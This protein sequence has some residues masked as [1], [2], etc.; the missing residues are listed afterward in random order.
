MLICVKKQD[1]DFF[2]VKLSRKKKKSS[3]PLIFSTHY[4]GVPLFNYNG[5]DFS[6]MYGLNLCTKQIVTGTYIFM[7]F[8]VA[9]D[10]FSLIL[11]H[12]NNAV[13]NDFLIFSVGTVSERRFC[14]IPFQLLPN[15][16]HLPELTTS[17]YVVESCRYPRD[18]NPRLA[19]TL[20]SGPVF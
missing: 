13:M 11:S 10:Y 16:I 5:P 9:R 8:H 6:K 15:E 7:E 3:H 14:D 19:C 1:I 18:C 12:K 4:P 20:G 2:R 17:Y